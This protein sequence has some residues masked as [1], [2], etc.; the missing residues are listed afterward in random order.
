MPTLNTTYADRGA[1]M[2]LMG[3]PNTGKTTLIGHLLENTAPNGKPFE[4]YILDLDEQL[5]PVVQ[6]I[7]PEHWD[8]CRYIQPASGKWQM[9]SQTGVTVPADFATM[10]NTL[11]NTQSRWIEPDYKAEP[12]ADW[13]PERVLV[14]DSITMLN[15]M[16]MLKSQTAGQPLWSEAHNKKIKTGR[17]VQVKD[18]MP[19]QE[20]LLDFITTF[21][22]MRPRRFHVIFTAHVNH[23]SIEIMKTASHEEIAEAMKDDK[24][25]EELAKRAK[26]MLTIHDPKK[27]PITPGK[28]AAYVIEGKFPYLLA[29][30]KENNK[31]ELQTRDDRGF[32]LRCN[33]PERKLRQY[34]PQKTGL[35]DV[36]AHHM[37]IG[38]KQEENHE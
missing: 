30:R 38:H 2:L 18:Y 21:K 33:D 34:L 10:W 13:G 28:A 31:V 12:Y 36:L 15:K 5:L 11:M 26:E 14:I 16:A 19:A 22:Y 4:L 35:A 6:G 9:D 17:Y 27:T 3:E 29:A 23:K 37:M 25:R 7:A 20:I 8:R 1:F 32:V 24:K